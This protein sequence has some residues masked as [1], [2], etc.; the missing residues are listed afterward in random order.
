MWDK[1]GGFDEFFFIDFVDNEYCKRL[2]LNGYKILRCNNIIINQ[3][4]GKIQLKLPYRVKF[5][6]R[7]SSIL[8]NK[9]VA[10]LSYKKEVSPLRVYYVHRNL[11]YLNKKYKNFGGIGYE[12]FYCHSF[13]GFLLYFSLPSFVRGS[14]KWKILKAIVRGLYD[15]HKSIPSNFEIIH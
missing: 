1:L 6:T 3:E 14:Q 5:Y 8:Y 10:K 15:G 11:L 13:R 12:N 9:N 2:V 7:L 4:F